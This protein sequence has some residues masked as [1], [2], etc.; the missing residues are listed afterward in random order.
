MN[1]VIVESP[2]KAKTIKKFLG[3]NYDVKA[4]MGHIIDLPKSQLG[5]DLESLEVKYITIRG[6]GEIL[7]ELKKASKKADKIFLAT[8]PDR[9]GEA[10]SWHLANSFGIDTTEKCR[11]VFNEITPKAIK[12]G[13][14]NPRTID[15]ALVDAQQA[16]RILDRIVG[17]KI[18]PLLWRKVK[19][20]LSA[21]RVQSV[22][23][24]LIVD[25]ERE[26]R[27][28]I[29]KEYWS[30]QVELQN[31]QQ[32]ILQPKLVS[33]REEKIEINSKEEMDRVISIIEKGQ[34]LVDKV[35]EAERQK[36]PSPP[37]TTSNLQQEAA[38]KLNFS[39][40]KT[41]MIAQQLYEGIKLG[42]RGSVGL[43][44][45]IR[46]DSTRLSDEFITDLRN[47]IVKNYGE[48]Y[49]SK[50]IRKYKSK[51]NAQEAH[52]A[53]RPTDLTNNPDEIKEFLTNDQYKLYKLI[54]LRTI[55][56]QMASALYNVLTIDIKNSDYTFRQ[57]GS[58]LKFSGFTEVYLEGQD[59]VEDE[60][61][62]F[63]GIVK[64][65]EILNLLKIDPKQHFT[66][67]PPRFTEAMLVKTLEEKGIGRPSTYAPIIDTISNR[68]YVIKEKKVFIPT[69]LG[70][71][72]T[73]LMLEH[74]PKIVDISFTAQMED[75]LDKIEEGEESWEDL[76]RSFYED[77]QKDLQKAEAQI[78]Q[79]ELEDEISDV[80]CEKCGKTMV[81]KLGKFGK[82]LACPGFPECRNTKT[83]VEEL[84]I[85]CPVCKQGKVVIRKTKK[86]RQ[87]FGCSRYPE[88]EFQSWDRPIGEN[89]P[90]CDSYLVEKGRGNNKK[91]VCS[92]EKCGFVKDRS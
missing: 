18:S 78:P 24:R 4:S 54:W 6:K 73:D 13:F 23:V 81:Y 58:I 36:H 39:P 52:E 63:K 26:I 61:L 60:E 47:Y 33:Y 49:I 91:F 30:L 48:K 84:G 90:K 75:K 83:L 28:F 43:I 88:C 74:F 50:E 68:G 64:E 86:G 9:E 70:E 80:I 46:T 45:Y 34:F 17:Y 42:K 37:F 5:V 11:V 2:S 15:Q 92:G 29:P 85:V 72:V 1:L 66:Q 87:F 41:M 21:G 55:A 56:S 65:G 27:D 8:D 16:R 57:T 10:I 19:K 59:E 14:K 7:K 40:K 38:R 44:T 20:G 67:P 69:E 32:E 12:E 82:F 3:K 25:R 35:K 22:A 31:A 76:I 53:I 89:C 79:V 77:F 62:A 51:K 71:I